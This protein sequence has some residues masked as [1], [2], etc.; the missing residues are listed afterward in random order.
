MLYS[1]RET[2]RQLGELRSL[3]TEEIGVQT[4]KNF[5]RFFSLH[6]KVGCV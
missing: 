2:A 3:S 5:Y 6:E 1:A 4:A